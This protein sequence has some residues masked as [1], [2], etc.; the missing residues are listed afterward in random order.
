MVGVRSGGSVSCGSERWNGSRR[1]EV[2][3][4]GVL[5]AWLVLG[6]GLGFFGGSDRLV[7]L[8]GGLEAVTFPGGGV[9]TSCLQ[10][11]L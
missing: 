10:G 4:C 6:L 8:W 7:G 9:V 2:R 11:V 3:F 5:R 1:D